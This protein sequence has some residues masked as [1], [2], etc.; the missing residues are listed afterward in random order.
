MNIQLYI[1]NQLCDFDSKTY[2]SLQ[3]EFEDETELIVKEIEYSYQIS[4]P[5]S[6]RNKQIF[7]YID[8]FDVPNKFGRVYDAELYVDEILIL[9]GKL[10]LTEID[11][12]YFKGNLYNP[13]SKTVSDILGDRQLNEIQEHLKPMNNL[14]DYTK[15]NNYVMGM[16]D[17][18]IDVEYRDNHVCYPYILYGLPMN[19]AEDAIQDNLDH[20][21]QN[22]EYGKHTIGLTN[23]F[24]SYNVCSLLK[25][26]FATEGYNVQGNIFGDE[27]F[28]DLYQT[29]Q[30]DY[31]K[32][33]NE[34]E[35]PYYVEFDV[36]Y[37]NSKNFNY[38]FP[39]YSADI[40]TTLQ[41]CTLWSEN[42]YYGNNDQ[43]FD[44]S[45]RGGVD[46]P[47]QAGDNFTKVKVYKNDQ[48]MLTR[49]GE[50]GGY[51]VRI[52]KSG[53]YRIH[54]SGQM[55]YTL[56]RSSTNFMDETRGL[57]NIYENDN[58]EAVGGM[59]D[60]AD[61]TSLEQQ[62]FEFQIKKGNPFDSPQ[63]YSFN[64]GIPCMPTHYSQNNTVYSFDGYSGVKCGGAD[65]Q[66]YYGKN[67]YATLIKE[68]SDKPISDFVAGARLGGALFSKVYDAEY[69]GY[70]QAANRFA[71][72]GELLAL[73][74]VDR[75]LTFETYNN[76]KYF[77]MSR[78]YTCSDFEYS[79]DTAQV[80]VRDDSYS[81]FQ[82]Y[83]KVNFETGAWDTTS[84]YGSRTYPF[85]DQ[86]TTFTRNTATAY[87]NKSGGWII[88]TV[89]WFE[90]GDNVNFEVIMP[91]HHAGTYTCCHSEWV[92]RQDYINATSLNFL[93]KMGFI[94]SEKTWYPNS[95]AP[96][97]TFEHLSTEKITNVNQFLPTTKCNDWLNKFL[98][99]FNLRLTMPNKNT[100][101]IDYATQNNI[102]GNIISIDGLANI[103]DAE[104][105][106]LD[107]P[108]TRQLE[109]KIDKNEAGYYWGN[110]SPYKTETNPWDE[111]GYTGGIS[112]TNESNTS[113]SIV[114]N[115][116]QWSY[117]W[118]KDIKFINGL[119]LSVSGAPISV[120]SEKNAWDSETTYL[121]VQG[122]NP[123]TTATSRLFFLRRNVDTQMC[124]FIQFKYDEL[125]G[126]D[127]VARL[128]IPSNSLVTKQ[129]NNSKRE[130]IL[131]YNILKNQHKSVKT[132]TDI[133]FNLHV[134]T[135]YQ[136]D[137]PIKL[138][139]DLYN[140]IN[141]GTLILFNDGLY[142]VKSIEGHDV[143]EH[144]DATLSLLTLN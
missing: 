3:K 132:I 59:F 98:Q 137:V 14:M 94:S 118:Y 120:I 101:S 57:K 134:Q 52:P 111:S 53:W 55:K 83:N 27:K 42:G 104:F 112:I 142:K 60:E 69:Y 58:T 7:G 123:K 127:L 107:L 80:L 54:C 85:E 62:P 6:S 25:D 144:D 135:G 79:K 143:T 88:N 45:Y 17:N 51:A 117:N 124:D 70:F 97:P 71:L 92:R 68:Y 2:L 8:D 84:N 141:A 38:T 64:S 136:V 21:T 73:P 66:T 44:G 1:E 105:K 133:F 41:T 4:I 140:R 129:A 24:P 81:E 48:H 103:K 119:G 122:D 113:G 35:S 18:L 46:C 126:Q 128:I 116:S 34:R 39:N 13:A 47:L 138:T 43:Y 109:W 110:Q 63:L 16:S 32:Y 30:Y 40:S 99:T 26:M 87:D 29:F 9:K 90:E 33:L 75:N 74:R 95:S 91:L 82:G 37:S 67:G 89:V 49:G 76:Q 78:D 23:V 10:K 22:L 102:M 50:Y 31:S 77:Q 100:F 131:D 15:T 12:E 108:S 93:F 11:S 28:K 5:T 130:Y 86:G 114:K 115:E 139:N 121:N 19:V 106:V 61:N 72:M 65:N 125:D 96:I 56:E 20:Y 36:D